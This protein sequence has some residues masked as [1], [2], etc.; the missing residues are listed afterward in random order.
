MKKEMLI[1]FAFVLMCLPA[2]TACGRTGVSLKA[3]PEEAPIV[4]VETVNETEP[5]EILTVV[6][7]ASGTTIVQTGSSAPGD[8][9]G[10][11]EPVRLQLTWDRDGQYG[12]QEIVLDR[13]NSSLMTDKNNCKAWDGNDDGYEDI[14]YYAGYTSGSG[15]CWNIYYLLCWSEENGKYESVELPWCNYISYEDHKLHSQAQ[16]G[17]ACVYY[18]IYGLQDGEYQYEKGLTLTERMS[19]DQTWA[20]VVE[21]SEDGEIVE[22]MNLSPISEWE[23]TKN[24]LKRRYP[25]FALLRR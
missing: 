17:N 14:L 12:E 24:I 13:I 19:E 11:R 6:E 16:D 1:N 15:G 25:E 3:P 18:E 23:E 21:Y 9:Y 22:T 4:Y 10:S 7:E 2:V 8:G 20:L 5:Q